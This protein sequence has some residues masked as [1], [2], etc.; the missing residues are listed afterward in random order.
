VRRTGAVSTQITLIRGEK[1]KSQNISGGIYK[2]LFTDRDGCAA[3]GV[4]G[5]ALEFWAGGGVACGIAHRQSTSAI[6]LL[7]LSLLG[8]PKNI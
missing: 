8:S 3:G 6:I 5:V 4:I 7:L 2:K 1:K